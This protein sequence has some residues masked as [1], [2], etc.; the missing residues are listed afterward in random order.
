MPVPQL[1]I[2]VTV[3]SLHLKHYSNKNKNFEHRVAVNM[4]AIQL[5]NGNIV[6]ANFAMR[7]IAARKKYIMENF[8]LVGTNKRNIP[9]TLKLAFQTTTQW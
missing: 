8:K 7:K 4:S 2:K 5:C 9:Y 6:N 1:Q 3:R